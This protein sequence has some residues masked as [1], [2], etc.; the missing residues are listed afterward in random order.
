MTDSF[1]STPKNEA[2]FFKGT[3]SFRLGQRSISLL[4]RISGLQYELSSRS[5]TI[6]YR[7]SATHLPNR[8]VSIF[9]SQYS[10]ISWCDIS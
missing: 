6:S 8:W 9:V 1:R 2:M 7:F 5:Y 3:A 10:I 4:Y